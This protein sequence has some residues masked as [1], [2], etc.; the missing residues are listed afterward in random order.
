MLVIGCCS[1]AISVCARSPLI[2][3]STLINFRAP[4]SEPFTLLRNTGLRNYH[5]SELSRLGLFLF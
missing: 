3:G 4:W 2:V 1:Q 5:F